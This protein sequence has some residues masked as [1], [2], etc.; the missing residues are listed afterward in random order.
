MT[1]S[2]YLRKSELVIKFS[3]LS[4]RRTSDS[5]YVR[6][7]LGELHIVEND[8]WAD[9]IEYSS[10]VDTRGDVVVPL[11]SERVYLCD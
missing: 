11:G 10:V 8:K 3:F 4:S 2:A 6:Y 1:I 7:L 9:D 5:K